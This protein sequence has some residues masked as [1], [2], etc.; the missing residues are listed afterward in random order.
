MAPTGSGTT[1]AVV[2]VESTRAS[3]GTP[4]KGPVSQLAAAET[5][6]RSNSKLKAFQS[7][8]KINP[9]GSISPSSKNVGSRQKRGSVT[10]SHGLGFTEVNRPPD[11]VVD[12]EAQKA[13]E[14]AKKE[15]GD[16][17][18]VLADEDAE[19][20]IDEEEEAD[21]KTAERVYAAVQKGMRDVVQLMATD[22]EDASLQYWCLDGIASLG[23]GNEGNR[24]VCAANQGISQIAAALKRFEKHEKVTV[25]AAWATSMMAADHAK[26]LGEAGVVESLCSAMTAQPANYDLQAIGTRALQ[27]MIAVPAN[28]KRANACG[29]NALVQFIIDDNP[30]DG[31]LIFRAQTLLSALAA[32]GGGSGGEAADDDDDDDEDEWDR[33]QLK[34]VQSRGRVRKDGTVEPVAKNV[35][36]RQKR[37]S[38]TVSHG[39]GFTEID[40]PADAVVDIE[41]QKALAAAGGKLG[42][43]EEEEDEDG[44]IPVEDEEE[45]ADRAVAQEV[46][47]EVKKG[48]R[49]V[50][51]L[52]KTRPDDASL[53]YWC[54]DGIASLCVGNEG[55]RGVCATTGGVELIAAALKK[56]MED[57]RVAVKCGWSIVA[58]AADY[59]ADLGDANVVELLVQ[60]M[61][62]QPA[63][64]DLQAIAVRALAILVEDEANLRRARE[65]GAAGR[66]Q[67]VMDANPDDGQLIFRSQQLLD[68]LTPPSG[69]AEHSSRLQHFQSRGRILEDGTVVPG[70]KNVGSKQKRGSVTVSHGLGF[71]E[72]DR[73]ADQVVDIEAQKAV[74]EA[75]AAAGDVDAVLNEVQAE[76]VEFD[77]DELERRAGTEVLQVAQK[78][79]IVGVLNLLRSKPDD[80]NTQWWCLDAVASLCVGKEDVR[81]TAAANGAVDAVVAA[82]RRHPRHEQVAVKGC[83]AV[84]VLAADLAK[85]I[86]E[87]G[88]MAA[89]ITSMKMQPANYQLQTIGCRAIDNL[90]KVPENVSLAVKLGAPDV[91]RAALEANPE[92]GQLVYRGNGLLA[93]LEAEA[94]QGAAE[95]DE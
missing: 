77:D 88:G 63:N 69:D 8:G 74:E 50:V 75:K 16:V 3:N 9:D 61:Q 21:R 76:E 43:E 95:G 54:L 93:T 31:Q 87:L 23:V 94:G 5:R 22:P 66:V 14:E 47:A 67:F 32:A 39:L 20:V 18:A 78:D 84:S 11:E 86:G 91:I 64:Y 28:A 30:E 70:S 44:A 49:D 13:L 58:M 72:I 53:Q 82:F 2:R 36:R 1:D 10:V 25:K 35:G 59:S 37:G 4:A 41:A 42:A 68:K 27:N 80:T 56:F 92:D 17:D 19:E 62:E 38:V 79:G 26:D 33:R 83:W 46:F 81:A 57:K 45:E 71:T 6:P 65:C 55:N 29:A 89:V 90:C 85:E 48:V 60:A 73:P 34:A 12:I 15:V 40:R 7:K 24:A 52:A 51:L